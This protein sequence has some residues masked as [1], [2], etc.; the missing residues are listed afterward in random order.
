MFRINR[1]ISVI[2]VLRKRH[3]FYNTTCSTEGIL[4]SKVFL[5]RSREGG[6]YR[7]IIILIIKVRFINW[8]GLVEMYRIHY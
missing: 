3:T 8:R 2:L 6:L 7:F 1:T 4:C 5:I